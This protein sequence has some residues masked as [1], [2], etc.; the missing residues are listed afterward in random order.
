MP[1]PC[2]LPPYFPCVFRRFDLNG[3]SHPSDYCRY[4]GRPRPGKEDKDDDA[5]V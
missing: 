5:K 3:L 4:C 2:G 1:W